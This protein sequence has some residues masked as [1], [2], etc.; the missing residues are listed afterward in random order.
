MDAE[1]ASAERKKGNYV[2][3]EAWKG[4][5]VLYLHLNPVNIV[6]IDAIKALLDA[7]R[8]L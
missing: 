6:E 2:V 4:P 7:D 1:E 3:E 8:L 5:P